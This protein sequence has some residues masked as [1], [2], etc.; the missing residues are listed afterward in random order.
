M[1][2]AC[3]R[4]RLGF[5][6]AAALALTP[7]AAWSK[8]T[9]LI[10]VSNEKTN[11]IIVIDPKTYQIVKDIKVARRPRDMHFNSD[12]T[13]LYI[14][15]GDDDVIDILDVAK[16]EPAPTP[17]EPGTD[18]LFEANRT[19]A[20]L[21]DGVNAAQGSMTALANMPEITVSPGDPMTQEQFAAAVPAGLRVQDAIELKDHTLGLDAHR[22]HVGGL[23]SIEQLEIVIEHASDGE[24]VWIN[25]DRAC[26]GRWYRIKHVLITDRR[27]V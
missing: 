18:A 4:N 15:C 1:M 6:F 17:P 21:D 13:K 20:R 3:L 11:N 12:H 19:N 22:P 24:R 8:D 23:R 16:L 14:A 5:L 2:Y 27:S 7:V 10:F 26:V 9:G 25:A